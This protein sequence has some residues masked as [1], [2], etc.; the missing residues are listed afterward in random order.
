MGTGIWA[1]AYDLQN[2][3]RQDYLTWFHEVHIPE[4]LSRPGYVWA[5]HF[6]SID[7]EAPQKPAGTCSVWGR[8]DSNLF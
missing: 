4:K 5:A 1:I 8:D 7:P 6:Q 3:G 2:G